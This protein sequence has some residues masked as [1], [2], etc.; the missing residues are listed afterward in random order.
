[1]G[2]ED[3]AVALAR[4][5][6]DLRSTARYSSS[7]RLVSRLLLLPESERPQALSPEIDK[8]SGADLFDVAMESF[9]RVADSNE[10]AVHLFRRLADLPMAPGQ[11]EAW[12][13]D[14]AMR[15]RYVA[16]AL[17]R[18]GHLREAVRE[19][20][21][22][23]ATERDDHWWRIW[24]DPFSYLAYLGA[25]P[26]EQVESVY[27]RG[28]EPG[29]RV[30]NGYRRRWRGAPWWAAR[31]DT[32]NLAVF[33]RRM[34][35]AA[36]RDRGSPAGH[37]ARFLEGEAA[38]FLAL[39]RGDTTGALMHFASIPDSLYEEWGPTVYV[40]LAEAAI[41]AARQDAAG[42]RAIL[43]RYTG[44][45]A[46]VL[47]VFAR[48]QRAQVAE[49]Q[50]DTATARRDFA[51]VVAAWRT[52]DPEFAPHVAEAKAGLARLGGAGQ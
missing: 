16:V 40:R 44:K 15:R 25:I 31:R 51:H 8:A 1:E 29:G 45:M 2:R 17:A 9:I 41:L 24:Q 30:E 10:T 47:A 19:I 37:R 12:V 6:A 49:R 4:V 22:D 14:S 20:A 50:G 3:R 27:R 48:L 33:E 32:A 28:L 43:D 36:V 7:V 34:H 11:A 38:G 18:R 13:V 21:S 35:E 26:A 39:V 23:L 42:A 52:A 5:A 46:G